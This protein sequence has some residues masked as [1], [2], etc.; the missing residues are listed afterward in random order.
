MNPLPII[1]TVLLS[2]AAIQRHWQSLLVGLVIPAACIS[3]IGIATAELPANLLYAV[4]ALALSAPFYVLFAIVCHRTVILG[5]DSLPNRFGI[6]WSDRELRFV[7]WSVALFLLMLVIAFFVGFF[8]AA[9]AQAIPAGPLPILFY[10]GIWFGLT[11]LY[12]RLSML[13]PATA[14]DERTNFD[15]A[16][17]L[18][19]RNGI[20][21]VAVGLLT[22]G[23]FAVLF[24][25]FVYLMPGGFLMSV[26]AEVLAHILTMVGIV[27]VSIT[28][29]QLIRIEQDQFG[30]PRDGPP[31]EAP[32][33]NPFDD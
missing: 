16:W 27:A 2:Y 17:Q 1:R 15:R 20:R 19:D 5:S 7:G 4:A 22:A 6:F 14:I 28:Y 24:F 10:F 33:K 32:P 26:I 13:F 9:A 8:V 11:Y 31:A 25:L 21:M 12:T 18:T 29:R 3:I 23:P 30:G